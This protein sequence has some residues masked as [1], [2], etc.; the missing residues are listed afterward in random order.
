M[1]TDLEKQEL[2]ASKEVVDHV[3]NEEPLP[4]YTPTVDVRKE[5]KLKARRF[6]LIFIVF[7]LVS[8]I[9]FSQGKQWGLREAHH[10]RHH[11]FMPPEHDKNMKH[12]GGPPKHLGKNMK[13]HG[14][15]SHAEFKQFDEAKLLD[16]PRPHAPCHGES[17]S[18]DKP[19]LFYWLF[20]TPN[21]ESNEKE[22]QE[23]AKGEDNGKAHM[24]SWSFFTDKVLFSASSSVKGHFQPLNSEADK[25]EST[26][27]TN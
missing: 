22:H 12:H 8:M 25:K 2:A 6:V 15:A 10:M 24:F 14:E 21:S 4:E 3:N 5:R 23:L 27:K 13:H 16:M 7:F 9:S 11:R 18:D 20:E 17:K 1:D 26:E 19:G